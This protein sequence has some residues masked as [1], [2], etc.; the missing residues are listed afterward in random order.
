MAR[1]RPNITLVNPVGQP[2]LR[3]CAECPVCR[4]QVGVGAETELLGPHVAHPS[5]RAKGEFKLRDGSGQAPAGAIIH[6][7]DMT[8]RL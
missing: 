6:G 5:V 7:A 2:V 3:A 1:N 8:R 4:K